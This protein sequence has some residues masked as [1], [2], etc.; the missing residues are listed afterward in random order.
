M[1]SNKQVIEESKIVLKSLKKSV[2]QALDR[3]KRLGQYAVIAKDGKII[4]LFADK[5]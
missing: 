4:K 5:I 2:A 1:Q 3:K